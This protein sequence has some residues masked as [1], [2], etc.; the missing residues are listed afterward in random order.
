MTNLE[1]ILKSRDITLLT[2]VYVVKAMAFTVFMY[3]C[4]SWIIKKIE[5]WRIDA[6]ELWSWIRLLGFP[7]TARGTNQSITKGINPEYSLEELIL[8]EIPIIWPHN[9][10]SRLTEKDLERLGAGG[11]GDD[12]G[13]VCKRYHWFN[14]HEFEHTQG[15]N[16][17]QGSLVCCSPLGFRELDMTW[18]LNNNNNHIFLTH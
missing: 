15:D 5:H 12:R 9:E 11:K 13:G 7:W 18:R 16:E 14:G 3:E 2:K 4:E 1:S 17:G 10:K 8:I 6:F